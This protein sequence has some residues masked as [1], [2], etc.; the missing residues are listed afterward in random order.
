MNFGGHEVVYNYAESEIIIL[1]V[2]YDETSTWMKG[3]DKGPDAILEASVNLEFYDIETS[4]EAH[5]KGIHTVA[6]VLEK[7]TPE[8]LVNAVYKRTHSLLTEKKFPVIIGGNHTV[9]I[10]AYR[11]YSE[12]FDDLSILQL[13]AHADLRPEYEGSKFN[14]AC[15]ISRAR[16]YAPVVQVGIRSMSA[17]ELPYLERERMFFAH[18][19]YYNKE[20]YRK[21]LD[22]LTSNVY[23]TIDLDVL[24]PS[25]MPSTGTPEPGGPE[26]FE[27]MH[28]LRDV[29]KERNVVGFDVVELCPSQSNKSPDFIAAKIIYQLLSY[30]FSSLQAL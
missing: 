25:L 5:L 28:F 12:I 2:P 24:D 29:I 30:K 20:L 11:A 10:G 6:P 8:E 13:D 14:H 15:A 7:E 22:K 21:A 26:Y 9:P 19:L 1:P 27:L 18:E 17:D 16:E 23:I 4:S 3:S